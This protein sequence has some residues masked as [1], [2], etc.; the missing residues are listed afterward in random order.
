M[1]RSG[2]GCSLRLRAVIL[3][4]LISGVSALV[5]PDIHRPA[6]S[7]KLAIKRQ[8][9]GASVVNVNT[10]S[11][12]SI[13]GDVG[14]SLGLFD[15]S[16]ALVSLN[17]AATPLLTYSSVYNQSYIFTRIAQVTATGYKFLGTV[18]QPIVDAVIPCGS[19]SCTGNIIHEVSTVAPLGSGL[20][21]L[22][23][24]YLYANNTPDYVHGYI[25]SWTAPAATGPWSEAKLLGWN[26][27]QPFSTTGVGQNINSIA[28]LTNCLIISEPSLLRYNS[29][30]Y[31]LAAMCNTP[32]GSI[33]QQNIVLLAASLNGASLG[34]FTYIATPL[35]GTDMPSL[36][37]SISDVSAPNL[38][39]DNNGDLFLIVSPFANLPLP[40]VGYFGCLTFALDKTT[41]AVPRTASGA[42]IP[43]S[44]IAPNVR[45]F[46]GA[47]TVLPQSKSGQNYLLPVL[48]FD[49]SLGIVNFTIL[50]TPFKAA[51]SAATPLL[52]VASLISWLWI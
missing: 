12:I 30:T 4:T 51:A 2:G 26:A 21:V 44:Y 5:A 32:V 15:P 38:F 28:G 24:T 36:G 14:S 16:M 46:S 8:P 47:C 31:L 50:P 3:F 33:L 23:H 41:F 34:P 17:G 6:L 49:L 11:P 19:S 40:S 13:E 10:T 29:S 39:M 48:T 27:G 1:R 37:F 22:T 43:I 20:I 25:S 52:A 18:N 42:P 45:F 9:P 35:L 7:A